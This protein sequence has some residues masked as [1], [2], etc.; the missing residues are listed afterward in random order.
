MNKS[1]N[2]YHHG[3]LGNA[4]LSAAEKLLEEKGVAGVSLR[5]TAKIA[6]VSH[7]APYRHFKDK[8]ALLAGLS[9]I[10]YA[11]LADA[12]E[13][14]ATD[15]P[16]NTL[17]QLADASHAYVNLATRHPQ[18]TNLMFGGIIRPEDC[19]HELEV[20]S[21]RAFMGLLN[22]IRNGQSSGAIVN[23]DPMEVALL[24]WSTVHGFSLLCSA[25]HLGKFTVSEEQV[26]S[27]VDVLDALLLRGIQN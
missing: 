25:G 27:L 6:G 18:M 9:T 8:T 20:I 12:M 2:S 23:K 14:C 26:H 10:G 24:V 7:A 11:R 1:T 4:L 16:E 19:T 13:Q 17:K 15:N 3:D 5:E 21:E 22:I